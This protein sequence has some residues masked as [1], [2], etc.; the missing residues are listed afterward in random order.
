[1]KER[2]FLA[3]LFV[4]M[5]LLTSKAQTFIVT[6]NEAGD[7]PI[8]TLSQTTSIYVD[9]NV[10]WLVHK[11]ASLLQND[12]EMVTGKKPELISTLPASAKNIIIIGTINGSATIDQ[13]IKEKKLNVDSVAG[14]WETFKLQTISNPIKGIQNAFV[15]VGSDKRGAA[16]GTFTL[17]EQLGVSL[18]LYDRWADVP[19]EKRMKCILKK[20]LINTGRLL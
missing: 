15:I 10:D 13:F 17:S 4:V 12:I 3:V 9:D 2:I 7:F 5:F 19:G 18:P 16:Y 20:V 14:K 1:M 11:A 8:V 6:K